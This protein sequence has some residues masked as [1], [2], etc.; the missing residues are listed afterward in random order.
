EFVEHAECRCEQTIELDG[1]RY[2]GCI[3][4]LNLGQHGHGEGG[5][6]V[7]DQCVQVLVDQALVRIL[8]VDVGN[9]QQA[10]HSQALRVGFARLRCQGDEPLYGLGQGAIRLCQE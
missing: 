7:V 5:G 1:H 10:A 3:Q 2:L 8:R 6:E 9:M 4:T